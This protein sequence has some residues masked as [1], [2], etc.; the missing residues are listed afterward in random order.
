MT[1]DIKT[2]TME[3]LM[4]KREDVFIG[5]V[6]MM[7]FG[8]QL[9]FGG[10]ILD[11]NTPVVEYYEELIVPYE[12]QNMYMFIIIIKNVVYYCFQIF[13]VYLHILNL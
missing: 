3:A 2:K 4:A 5:I 1:V 10:F 6:T 11:D 7:A 8:F 13:S 12:D 9:S